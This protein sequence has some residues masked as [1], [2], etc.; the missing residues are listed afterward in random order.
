MRA[1]VVL[2]ASNFFYNRGKGDLNGHFPF[3]QGWP[4]NIAIQYMK[5]RGKRRLLVADV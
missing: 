4:L 3:P 5:N 1:V 2:D